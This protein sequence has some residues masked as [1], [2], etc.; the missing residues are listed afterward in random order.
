MLLRVCL[1]HVWAAERQRPRATRAQRTAQSPAP[2]STSWPQG[3]SQ[4]PAFPPQRG[5]APPALHSSPPE[6]SSVSS[7]QAYTDAVQMPWDQ[8][9]GPPCLS[10]RLWYREQTCH[11]RAG[12]LKMNKGAVPPQESHSSDRRHHTRDMGLHKLWLLL[13]T[14]VQYP[15]STGPNEQAHVPGMLGRK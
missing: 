9:L 6:Q 15:C 3:P 1:V 14:F 11:P 10:Q 7:Q 5:G 2:L 12:E 8:E 13:N 4:G